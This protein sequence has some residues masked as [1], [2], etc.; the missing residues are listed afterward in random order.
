MR[1]VKNPR[2]TVLLSSLNHARFVAEAIQ[3]VLDQTFRDFELFIIDDCSDDDSWAVIQGFSDP[4]IRAVR[5]ATRLRGADGFNGT[6]RERAAGEYVAIHHSDDAWLPHKLARQ[7]AVL[8]ARPEVAAVFTRVALV[9]E[10]GAPFADPAHYYQGRFDAPN[11]PRHEWLRQFFTQGNCL[12]HPSALVRRAAMIEAGLYDRRLGQMPDFDLWV[13]LC[14]AHEIHVL[15]EPLTRFR[16]LAREANQ[17]AQ[18]PTTEI[19]ARNEIGLILDRFLSIRDEGLFF[20]AFPEARHRAQPQ[21]NR[22]PFL[23]AQWALDHGEPYHAH[24]ALTTLYRLMADEAVAAELK[25][26]HDFG[27]PELVALAGR[28]DPF[29][30][31][32]LRANHAAIMGLKEDAGRV[33]RSASWRLTAPLRFLARLLGLGASARGRAPPP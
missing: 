7:V 10:R 22:L 8:D 18:T 11:R 6:I 28:L 3:S 20:A 16:I 9:D 1:P 5:N 23:L 21:D 24:F 27:Y 25:E 19:R 4:R 32:Q 12:C 30:L 2:V 26:R 31:A 29:H 33:R 17:S 13:R 15:D 14:L